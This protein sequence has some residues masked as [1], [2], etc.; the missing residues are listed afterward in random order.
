MIAW[1]YCAVST[2]VQEETLVDQEAW[3]RQVAAENGWDLTRVFGGDRRGVGSGK[4]GVRKLLELLVSEIEATPKKQR[5]ERVLM[6]RLDRVGRMALD[7]IGMLARIRR[8]GVTIVTRVDG[9]IRLETAADSLKPIFE[10]ITAEIE[11]AGRQDKTRAAHARFRAEGKHFGPAPYGT[12]KDANRR[13]V[14]LEPQATFVRKAFELRATGAGYIRIAAEVGRDAPPQGIYNG[15]PRAGTWH[16]HTVAS[17]LRC[18]SYRG[19]V[20]TEDLFDRA[21]SIK[22]FDFKQRITQRYPWPLQGLI[23][24]WCGWTLT[25]MVGGVS[26]RPRYRY[27]HCTHPRSHHNAGEKR[28][29]I[30]A[31]LAEA[32]FTELLRSIEY[33]PEAIEALRDA[34]GPDLDVLRETLRIDKLHVGMIDR[35][36]EAA[37]DLQADGVLSKIDLARRIAE[38]SE[39]RS[40]LLKRIDRAE[41][42]IAGVT[43]AAS[44]SADTMIFIKLAA[45]LWPKAIVERQKEVARL[46]SVAAGG[47][48]LSRDFTVALGPQN[49]VQ[50]QRTSSTRIFENQ[51]TV[52]LADLERAMS[53]IDEGARVSSSPPRA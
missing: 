50:V 48:H 12:T 14:P 31:D 3:C 10:L 11:N 18:Q 38:L 29:S 4:N 51:H 1:A 42:T 26:S 13:L 32:Q 35:R 27:Y 21:S 23:I 40:D 47:I 41:R 7:A 34:P 30:R 46:V 45:E 52:W 5:P 25:G 36:R 2:G 28:P 24:C 9:A 15:R 17:M 39:E 22:N 53:G 37:Y 20:V 44:A 49:G 6:I 19:L 8:L 16:R 43:A 33:S